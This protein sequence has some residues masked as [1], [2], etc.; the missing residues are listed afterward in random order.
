MFGAGG[1]FLIW[2]FL[3]VDI[4]FSVGFLVVVLVDL[5]GVLFLF[6]IYGDIEFRYLEVGRVLDIIELSFFILLVKKLK[7]REVK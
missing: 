4:L 6:F 2:K 7:F 3:T 1:G 5:C